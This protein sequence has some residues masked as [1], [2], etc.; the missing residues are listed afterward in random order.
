MLA[1]SIVKASWRSEAK[2]G[3]ASGGGLS[4]RIASS[5]GAFTR[6]EWDQL[7]RHFARRFRHGYNPFLSFDFLSILEESGCAVPR[8]GWQGQHLRLEDARR[9]AARRGALLC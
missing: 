2:H 5:I 6:A 3:A 7:C 9:R 4:I 1:G 8:T